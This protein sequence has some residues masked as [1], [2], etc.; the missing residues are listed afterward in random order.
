MRSWRAGAASTILVNN[1]G[2]VIPGNAEDFSLDDWRRTRSVNLDGV[3]LVSRAVG[4]R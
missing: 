2:I 4:G 1:A 3:F